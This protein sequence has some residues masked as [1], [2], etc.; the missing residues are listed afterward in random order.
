MSYTI[1]T[2]VDNVIDALA[3]FVE[4]FTGVGTCIRAEVNRTAMPADP[5]VL[6]TELF[7]SDL[8]WP[9]VAY[10]PAATPS[11]TQ[12]I[13]GPT[14]ITV[15]AD[16]YGESSGDFCRAVKQAI[17]SG[18]GFDQFPANVK[19]LFSDDGHQAPITSGEQQYERRWIL[20]IALQYN[21]VLTVPQDFADV[22]AA[23]IKVPAD[24]QT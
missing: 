16:F 21:P 18:W 23:I 2:T 20:T 14:K 7:S 4:L 11:S 22:A 13:T 12:T 17:R 1:D 19:P 10:Q 5:F 8:E 24:L 6:L 3:T 9:I 15:Q